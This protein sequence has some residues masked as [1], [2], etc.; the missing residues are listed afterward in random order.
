MER[1]KTGKNPWHSGTWSILIYSSKGLRQA[2]SSC[3]TK[4]KFPSWYIEIGTCRGVLA[5]KGSSGLK[6]SSPTSGAT[7]AIPLVCSTHRW[8]QAR[9]AHFVPLPPGFHICS[10]QSFSVWGP[11][12]PSYSIDWLIISPTKSHLFPGTYSIYTQPRRTK[13]LL[14]PAISDKPLQFHSFSQYFRM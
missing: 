14:S 10:D 2:W 4:K 7:A 13:W 9:F 12:I 6:E 5:M 1:A 3:L 11:P 8:A